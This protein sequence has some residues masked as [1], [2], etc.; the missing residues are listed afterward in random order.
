MVLFCVSILIENMILFFIS[1]FIKNIVLFCM[2]ILIIDRIEEHSTICV[3]I[4]TGRVEEHGI[5]L[6]KHSHREHD[7]IL[8]EHPHLRSH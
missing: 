6:C 3:S 1:I 5:I 7:T 4:L 8:Y 2:S